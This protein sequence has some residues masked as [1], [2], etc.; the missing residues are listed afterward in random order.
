MDRSPAAS[1]R[2]S[3][4]AK[5]KTSTCCQSRDGCCQTCTHAVHMATRKTVG[6]GNDLKLECNEQTLDSDSEAAVENETNPSFECVMPGCYRLRMT[7]KSAHGL[8]FDCYDRTSMDSNKRVLAV[9]DIQ[10]HTSM[11]CGNCDKRNRNLGSSET[12]KCPECHYEVD[13]D[14]NGAR[15]ISRETLQLFPEN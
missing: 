4:F 15:N 3:S 9:Q 12:F 10:S 1:S 8:C 14:A 2:G 5:C 11:T 13:R 7:C 6:V